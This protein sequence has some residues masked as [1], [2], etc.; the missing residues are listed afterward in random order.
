VAGKKGE[1]GRDGLTG[2]KGDTGSSGKHGI[3]GVTGYTGSIGKIGA[4]G[5]TGYT[6]EKGQ[7][8]QSGKNGSTGYTGV[9]GKKGEDGRDGPTGL[10]GDT[11]SNGKDGIMGLRGYTGS[12]G[13]TGYTGDTGVT[14]Y[15]GDTGYTGHTG[16]TGDTGV[17]GYTG[18]T[19]TPGLIGDTGN[20]GVT[21]PIGI[22][23]PN[24]G[25]EGQFLIKAS[26]NDYDTSWRT[27]TELLDQTT[28]ALIKYK[29]DSLS[30]SL[31]ELMNKVRLLDSRY[32]MLVNANDLSYDGTLST[33]TS[34]LFSYLNIMARI[35][36]GNSITDFSFG[37]SIDCGNFTEDYIINILVTIDGGNSD[38]IDTGNLDENLETDINLRNVIF[39]DGGTSMEYY[40]GQPILDCGNSD[41][42][43]YISPNYSSITL[44]NFR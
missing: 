34:S 10:K 23:I 18:H 41:G 26:N 9:A 43:I 5:I 21:G 39:L 12:I 16:D 7:P 4:T 15:T 36:G 11:G 20:T 32:S 35:D 44:E 1:D 27:V 25:L 33:R 8:G 29:V 6:G 3:M 22:G 31:S 42:N 30:E 40:T 38:D 24:G 19:G 17:T 28:D 37:P 13:H 14:G 2:L